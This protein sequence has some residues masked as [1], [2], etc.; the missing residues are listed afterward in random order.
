M[1]RAAE[2]VRDVPVGGGEAVEDV[3]KGHHH[4]TPPKGRHLE[5]GPRHVEQRPLTIRTVYRALL[6]RSSSRGLLPGDTGQ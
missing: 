2:R 6:E 4:L 3:W 5:G 1:E